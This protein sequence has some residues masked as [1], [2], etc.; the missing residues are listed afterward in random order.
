MLPC[1][2]GREEEGGREEGGREEGGRREKEKE[3]EKE[4]DHTSPTHHPNCGIVQPPL[5]NVSW[6]WIGVRQV[7]FSWLMNSEYFLLTVAE[8]STL[9]LQVKKLP[10]QLPTAQADSSST[11]GDTHQSRSILLYCRAFCYPY[12][13]SLTYFMLAQTCVAFLTVRAS[14]LGVEQKNASNHV[15]GIRLHA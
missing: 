9:L 5:D 4:K 15:A 11:G 7:C 6:V 1:V 2:G 10:N 3:R 12:H 13:L 14:V 8:P